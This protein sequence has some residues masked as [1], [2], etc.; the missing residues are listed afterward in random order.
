M[1]TT[2]DRE[3]RREYRQ[4]LLNNLAAIVT[5]VDELDRAAAEARNHLHLHDRFFFQHLAN[6]QDDESYGTHDDLVEL[7]LDTTEVL[8]RLERARTHMNAVCKLMHYYDYST[9]DIFREYAAREAE[10]L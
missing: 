5:T 6:I 8:G 4:R 9:N 10:Y 7:Y 1:Q 3:N 2:V